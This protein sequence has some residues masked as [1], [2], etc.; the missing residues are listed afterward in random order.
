MPELILIDARHDERE[1]ESTHTYTPNG[2]RV[3]KS[4][5]AYLDQKNHDYHALV[6][7]TMDVNRHLESIQTPQR[8]QHRCTFVWVY[9]YDNELSRIKACLHESADDYLTYP[10]DYELLSLKHNA[11]KRRIDLLNTL[12]IVEQKPLIMTDL[13]IDTMSKQVWLRD[14]SLNLTYSEFCIFYVLAKNPDEVFTM[15]YL[16]HTV[17]GQK[18][19][20]DYNALMTHI[21]RLRRKISLIDPKHKY[22]L[23]VRNKG[24]KFNVQN[25]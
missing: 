11:L 22:I 1:A 25:K 7:S 18:S 16:F 2:F 15:E 9:D 14:Q 3:Y 12:Y 20:G 17:T 23:T 8:L 10:I 6:L 13:Y 19:L 4:Y 21:S 24:Y 5:Q